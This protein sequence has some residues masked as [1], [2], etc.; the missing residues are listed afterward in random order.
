MA[1]QADDELTTL[2]EKPHI[3][4]IVDNFW[5]CGCSKWTDESKEAIVVQNG[6][7]RNPKEAYESWREERAWNPG[8]RLRMAKRATIPEPQPRKLKKHLR[9]ATLS[10][11]TQTL[12]VKK[13]N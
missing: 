10:A 7:G 4:L 3:E 9:S 1:Y 5:V 11:T 8:W 13:W 6:Y 2:P 12:R